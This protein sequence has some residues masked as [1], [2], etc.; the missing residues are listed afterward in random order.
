MLWSNGGLLESG[1]E[2]SDFIKGRQY[3]DYYPPK[4]DS[5]P[6]S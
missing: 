5:V 3:L 4:E 6:S 1:N 2:L